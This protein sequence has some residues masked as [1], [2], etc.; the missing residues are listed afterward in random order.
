[1]KNKSKKKQLCTATVHSII[2]AL[3][4]YQKIFVYHCDCRTAVDCCG[5]LLFCL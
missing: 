4:F 3:S 2:A 1:M 5:A